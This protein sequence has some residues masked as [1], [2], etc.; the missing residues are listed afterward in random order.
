MRLRPPILQCEG[1]PRGFIHV[2]ELPGEAAV[3]I[4]ATLL[5]Q[6]EGG[7]LGGEGGEAVDELP[8]VGSVEA[9]DAVGSQHAVL[10]VEG[11]RRVFTGRLGWRVAQCS[12]KKNAAARN[13]QS[14]RYTQQGYTQSYT[15]AVIHTRNRT[16]RCAY[17][18]QRRYVDKLP[19]VRHHLLHERLQVPQDVNV[20][21]FGGAVQVVGAV[22]QALGGWQHGV[23]IRN[24]G[25]EFRA[26]KRF[27]GAL[28]DLLHLGTCC[29]AMSCAKSTGA[30][31]GVACN[32]TAPA[33]NAGSQHRQSTLATPVTVP[34]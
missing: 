16:Q 34:C 21:P 22:A 25:A 28:F 1:V 30:W 2:H 18:W 27:P 8:N 6:P 10:H 13:E 33:V 19:N 12:S 9:I 17:L 7:E 23:G 15:H 31:H 4:D 32:A 11:H 3:A 20:A 24:G 29:C 5:Q 14:C 26:Q